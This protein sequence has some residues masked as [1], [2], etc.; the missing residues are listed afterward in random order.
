MDF[1]FIFWLAIAAVYLFQFILGKKKR[2]A[3]SNS[4]YPELESEPSDHPEGFRD[5]LSEIS[6]MLS[7]ETAPAPQPAPKPLPAPKSL[8]VPKSLHA[9]TKSTSVIRTQKAGLPKLTRSQGSSFFDEEFEK[10]DYVDFHAPKIT[11][12]K[13]IA[14]LA[15]LAH[16]TRETL[17][18]T[19]KRDIHDFAKAQ[20]ALVLAEVLGPPV[21]K[22]RGKR[23][24]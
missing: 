6:R 16:K 9:P 18:V 14:P 23:R 22:R 11:H 21:S 1:D 19:A 24:I 15:P 8:S 5:A 7:G 2:A 3:N 10:Q 12:V 13:S 20:E 17:M 4:P